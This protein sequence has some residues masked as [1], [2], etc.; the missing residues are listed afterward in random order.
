MI[1]RLHAAGVRVPVPSHFIDGVRGLDRA[2][3]RS[4][5]MRVLPTPRR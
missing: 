4:S 3:R 2:Q 1:H 5:F